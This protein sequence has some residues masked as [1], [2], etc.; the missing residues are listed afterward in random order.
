M[1]RPRPNSASAADPAT[2]PPP[3]R[4]KGGLARLRA[5]PTE[6]APRIAVFD[7]W[8]ARTSIPSSRVTNNTRSSVMTLPM[9]TKPWVCGCRM[10]LQHSRMPC[11]ISHSDHCV[12]PNRACVL[13]QGVPWSINIAS[14]TPQRW[15]ASASCCCTGSAWV[16]PVA[17]SEFISIDLLLRL[18]RVMAAAD[19]ISSHHSSFLH[20]V[21][22]YH[23]CSVQNPTRHSQ[24][25]R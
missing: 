10:P 7:E 8:A 1:C 5:T 12:R 20:R 22:G 17:A 15:K 2:D 4:G 18:T 16:P 3:S 6:A 9:P 13:H 11:R 19:R 24:R 23:V 25:H 21:R 14:G